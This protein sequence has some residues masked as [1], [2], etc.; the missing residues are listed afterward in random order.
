[1]TTAIVLIHPI[2]DYGYR[3]L[4]VMTWAGYRPLRHVCQ[5]RAHAERCIPVLERLHARWGSSPILP[6]GPR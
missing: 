4:L 3:W 6:D 2:P 5:S 1:M